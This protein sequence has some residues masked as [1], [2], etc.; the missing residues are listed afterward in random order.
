M[1][2]GPGISSGIEE[3][4]VF[5]HHPPVEKVV[6]G[7]QNRP[8]VIGVAA[9]L[10]VMLSIL[11]SVLSVRFTA[12]G[13]LDQD[14]RS[15]L[16]RS[17]SVLASTIDG[18]LHASLI[19]PEQ[20]ATQLYASMNQPLSR[21]LR[22][23]PGIRYVYTLRE[24][25]GK[26]HF[27]LDGTPLGDADGDGVEDHSFLMDVYEDP[28]SAS[29][30]ALREGRITVTP[31]AFTD[32]W[33]TFQSAYAPIFRAD[34]SVDGVVGIDVD[35]SEFQARLSKVDTATSWVVVPAF[36][37][38]VIAGL[39]AR[40]I[41]AVHYRNLLLIESH[42]SDA[43]QANRAKSVLL[44]NVSH[45][46]RTPMTAIMGFG[47]IASDPFVS[48][49]DR[50]EALTTVRHN[51][52]H[53]MIL[54][55]DL[56]DMSTIEAQAMRL[57]VMEVDLQNLVNSAIMPL[58]LRAQEKGI[59]VAVSCA[60]GLPVSA[61]L[62]PTRTRQIL[63]NL[64]SNAVKF[65][66]KG[67][68]VLTMDYMNGSLVF[69]VEDTGPGMSSEQI[70]RLFT[71]FCQVGGSAAKRRE[72]T[73]LGLAISKHLTELMGGSIGVQSQPGVGSRFTVELPYKTAEHA[74]D[75]DPA[76]QPAQHATPLTGLRVLV[77]EDGLDNMR[78]LRLFLTTAGADILEH[79]DG[80]SAL[81]AILHQGVHADL[82]L[83][84]WNMPVLDGAGL[85]KG[86]RNAK[87]NGPV[88]SLTASAT[89]EQ[90]R[91][92]MEAGCDAHLTKPIERGRLIQTCVQL[93]R[94]SE[95]APHAA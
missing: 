25:D 93:L 86:L 29:T 66:E 71:P 33:G 57:E 24:T 45:E 79:T 48:T 43:E 39:L 67:T 21:A 15:N 58:R 63:L 34:G 64:L 80:Q 38:S 65:T 78:L 1:L 7:W 22:V 53:L 74:T 2:P 16:A 88:V 87:W 26:V 4:T 84:D 70:G 59:A 13:V 40:W 95:N 35:S 17:A 94:K 36:L 85:V 28:C 44:A 31:E 19:D 72:G 9:G 91:A 92:C 6:A 83:T 69:T 27:V 51:A 5:E 76:H 11:V 77:A 18:E 55:N 61:M 8:W 32:R 56:L 23:I 89:E 30:D 60:D 81:D 20:E 50:A 14:L 90:Q 42:R 10:I 49:S 73:G 68:V 41:T 54:I 12:H 75:P 47:A 46:L 37:L 3:T 52:E 62:D 82:V